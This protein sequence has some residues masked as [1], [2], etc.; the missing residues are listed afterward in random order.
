MSARSL[1]IGLDGADLDVIGALGPDRLPE[2]HRLMERG[3][4]ARLESVKPFATLPNWTTF[5]TGVDPGRHGVFDF[6]TREGYRVAF[7]AGTVREA[8]TV[9][10]RLDKLGL[11]CACVGFPATWP[12]EHLE[13]GVF[14]SGWDSPVAFE[15]DRS[16][17]WPP[18]VHDAITARFGPMRFDDVDEFDAEREGW[19]ARLPNALIDRIRNKTELASWLLDERGWDLFAF[20]FGESDTAAHHLWSLWDAASPRHPGGTSE[21]EREGLARVYEALD[22]AVGTLVDRAGGEGVEVTLISDHGSGGA[23]DEVLYLNR[24]LAEAGLLTFHER[25]LIGPLVTRA[26]DIALTGLGGRARQLLFSL[27]G[28]ALPGL[29]ES[30]ARY[31]AIDFDRTRAFSDELNYFPSVSFNV[32]GREPRGIVEPRDLPALTRE[33]E[34]VLRSIVSPWSGERVVREVWPREELYEGPF[35]ES[36]AGSDPRAGA[37]TRLQR[38]P[39]ALRER[40]AGHRPVAATEPGRA[41]RPQGPQPP[42]QPPSLRHLHRRRPLGRAHGRGA[43]TDARRHRH[44][45]RADGHRAE[46][47]DERPRAPRGAAPQTRRRSV[48]R[49]R[50]SRPERR[51]SRP[52]RAPPPRARLHRL[53]PAPGSSIRVSLPRPPT[54]PRAAGRAPVLACLSRGQR[55]LPRKRGPH[56]TTYDGPNFR[57]V[58]LVTRNSSE[59]SIPASHRRANQGTTTRNTKGISRRSDAESRVEGRWGFATNR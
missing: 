33:V 53:V 56:P 54:H 46:R 32:R 25:G 59:W 30:R 7:T 42:G 17:V 5:L 50:T 44:P 2:L 6:T 9:A 57:S 14:I 21:A 19:H 3:A 12:P 18:S 8:P 35:V 58:V 27:A 41:P 22:A 26:K 49:G 45:A 34:S 28:R 1:V 52:P 15:A 16:F 40:T 39:H 11:A 43:R 13:H 37:L 51:Q 38:E 36:G 10:A 20:Y 4:W 48:A 55:P 29:V 24:A 23:S 31:G 47:R